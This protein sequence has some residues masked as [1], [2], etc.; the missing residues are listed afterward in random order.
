MVSKDV[1]KCPCWTEEPVPYLCVV[2][3]VHSAA[4]LLQEHSSAAV[5]F[6]NV[7]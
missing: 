1:E 6:Q 7:N 3:S 2:V 5:L 4:R